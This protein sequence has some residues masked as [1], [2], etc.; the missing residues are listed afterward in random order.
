MGLVGK[1][2]IERDFAQWGFG[3]HHQA[4]CQIDAAPADEIVR[5]GAEARPE[6][7]AEIAGAETRQFCQIIDGDPPRKIV[8]DEAP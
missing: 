2:A 4:F 1:A 8:F 3:L 6:G 7:G 5:G